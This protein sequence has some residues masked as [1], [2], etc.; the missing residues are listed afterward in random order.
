MLLL[1]EA[2]GCSV[3]PK[4]RLKSSAAV[5]HSQEDSFFGSLNFDTEIGDERDSNGECW[6]KGCV[7][8]SGIAPDKLATATGWTGEGILVH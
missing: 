3:H 4:S 1:P 5:P 7:S 8:V 6:T 2:S